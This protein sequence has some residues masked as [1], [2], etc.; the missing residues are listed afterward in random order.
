MGVFT[1]LL[2]NR[3]ISDLS[4]FKGGSV[5]MEWAFETPTGSFFDVYIT[6]LLMYTSGKCGLKTH[7]WDLKTPAG[8]DSVNDIV[9]IVVGP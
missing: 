5:R 9:H 4:T 2:P 7:G 6:V 1:G 3:R 8:D